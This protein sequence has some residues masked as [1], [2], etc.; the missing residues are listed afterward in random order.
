MVCVPGTEGKLRSQQ[1]FSGPR[2]KTTPWRL[3]HPLVG[4]V[5]LCS[6]CCCLTLSLPLPTCMQEFLSFWFTVTFLVPRAVQAQ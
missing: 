5:S 3:T 1:A 6:N 2:I 4:S